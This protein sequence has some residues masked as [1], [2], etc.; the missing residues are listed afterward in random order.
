MNK[1]VLLSILAL[2][3]SSILLTQIIFAQTVENEIR[4]NTLDTVENATN[5]TT[6]KT[7]NPKDKSK[8]PGCMCGLSY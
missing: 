4:E 2:F 1:I 3:S 7:I 5:S 8:Q 6:L